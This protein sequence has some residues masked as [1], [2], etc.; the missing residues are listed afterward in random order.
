[1]AN[2]KKKHTPM[3]RDMRR[4]QNWRLELGSLSRCPHCGG[5]RPPH[6][7]CPACGYYGAELILP[8]KVK[9]DK[10]EKS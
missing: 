4:A 3:R 1:M 7:L 6:R 2:P 9:K 5:M 8:P 10:K